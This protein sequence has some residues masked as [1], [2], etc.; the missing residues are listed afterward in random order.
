MLSILLAVLSFSVMATADVLYTYGATAVIPTPGSPPPPPEPTVWQFT[1]DPDGIGYAGLELQITGSLTPAT[2]TTLMAEYLMTQGTFGGGAPRFTL[3]DGVFNS[4]WIYWGTPLGGNSFSDPY[5]GTAW[6]ST[7]NYADLL[8]NDVR[9]YSN[10]FGGDC[11]SNTG[12]TWSAFVALVGATPITY[13]TLDL[14][15][16]FATTQQM[17][18]A[19]WVVNDRTYSTT[20]P[21]PSALLLLGSGVL[22]VAAML[23]RKINAKVT[24]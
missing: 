9:V 16:G 19:S 12:V 18:V 11:N 24:N 21:E 10:C 5:G 22:G 17:L 15:G 7:G 14:D 2:L 23:R 6:G 8:S 20:T 3:F 1:S 13:I 4:A